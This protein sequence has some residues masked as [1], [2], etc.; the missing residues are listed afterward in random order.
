ML[1]E[2]QDFIRRLL[3]LVAFVEI[4]DFIRRLLMFL[5]FEEIQDFKILLG[6]Y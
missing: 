3:V 6:D 2:I 4:Q 5:T 1:V